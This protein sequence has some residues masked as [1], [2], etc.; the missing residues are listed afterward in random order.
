MFPDGLL[1]LMHRL[2]RADATGGPS[3]MFKHP[4][5][6]IVSGASLVFF[7]L[8]QAANLIGIVH[9]PKDIREALIAMS[10]VST[11]LAYGILFVGLPVA[12]KLC[13]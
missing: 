11:P 6:A 13:C 1:E 9:L 2:P 4:V 3:C 12:L 7:F 5:A 8:T 10:N